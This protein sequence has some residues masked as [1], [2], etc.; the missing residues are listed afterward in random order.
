[1]SMKRIL[2]IILLPLTLL[3]GC[4]GK[5]A[6]PPED[7][8]YRLYAERQ[9]LKVAQIADF[10][11][12]DSVCVGVVMVQA[13]DSVAWNQLKE[14]F[15]IRDTE[16]TVSWLADYSNPAQR[17]QWAGSPVLRVIAS[18]ERQAIGFYRIESEE[19]YDALVDYQIEKTKSKN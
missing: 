5:Q 13:E 9:D 4:N 17:I 10:P 14:E 11:L 19:Q 2:F 1:M 7:S 3:V 15:D 8:L 16:G 18:H 6:L 12:C